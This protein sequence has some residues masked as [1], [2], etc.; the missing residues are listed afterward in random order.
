MSFNQAF[1]EQIKKSKVATIDVLDKVENNVIENIKLSSFIKPTICAG[2]V[3]AAS[4]YMYNVSGDIKL[5]GY[6]IPFY[7]VYGGVAFLS[8]FIQEMIH[9]TI[10]NFIIDNIIGDD[11]A[12]KYANIGHLVGKPFI[13]AGINGGVFYLLFGKPSMIGFLKHTGIIFGSEIAAQY[14]GDIIDEAM[15]KE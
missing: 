2:L 4:Y 7:V 3:G 10:A 14:V 8:S 13:S 9:E 12:K 6:N 11:N 15:K 1:K 5:M